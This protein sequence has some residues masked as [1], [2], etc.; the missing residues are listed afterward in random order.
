MYMRENGFTKWAGVGRMLFVAKKNKPAASRR[1][2]PPGKKRETDAF[3]V[4]IPPAL[5]KALLLAA[6]RGRRA[7]NAEI[8][9]AIEKHLESLGL[10]TPPPADE[11]LAE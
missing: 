1:G 8:E 9:I 3:Q 5:H 6:N 4:R 10:W 11:P 2:R 7:K